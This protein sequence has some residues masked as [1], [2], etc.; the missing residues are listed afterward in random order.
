MTE[1]AV[2][3]V[4]P[5]V[6]WRT[7]AAGCL[8]TVLAV[9]PVFLLGGLA[10]LVRAELGFSEVQLGLAASAF[11]AV[12]ALSAV[13]SG[14]V[15][16]LVGAWSATV[17]AAALSAAALLTMA[18]APSYVV[19]LGALAVGGVANSLAQMGTNGSLAQVVPVRQQGVAFGVKQAAIPAATLVAGFGVPLVGLTLGWR[20]SFAGTALLAVA[21]VVLMPRP[22]RVRS[23]A[24]RAGQRAGDAAVRVLAVV[25]LAAGFAAAAANSLAA[26]LVESAVT[27]GF[28]LSQAGVLLGCG[29]AVGVAARIGTG[30]LAD[31]YDR[32]HLAV[33]AGMMAVG[34]VALALLATA[35]VPAFIAGTALVFGLGWTWPGLLTYAVVRLN[36]SAPA[37]A[38]SYTQT[39]V[40][41]GS[42]AGPVAFGLLV[43][44][45]SYRLAWSAAAAAMLLAAALMLAARRMLLAGRRP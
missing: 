13:P 30:W 5:A 21:F 37:V 18:L 25:A 7:V 29:S 31:R 28:S 39:G 20:A 36:P 10:V 9:L 22:A 14:R 3:A 33:V 38:T 2:A 15:A 27:A 44:A 42:A 19:L 16:A 40:F 8:S 6:V 26:F 4:R 11:F 24:P 23:P 12:A 17:L 34:A 45:G 32:G 1:T 35:A 41:A 43:Q